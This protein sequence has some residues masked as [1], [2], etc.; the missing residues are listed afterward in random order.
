MARLLVRKVAKAAATANPGPA[1]AA[2]DVSASSDSL[3]SK[4]VSPG[5]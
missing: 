1:C 3:V 2:S 4:V 5:D